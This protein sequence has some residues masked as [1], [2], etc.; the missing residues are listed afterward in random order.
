LEDLRAQVNLWDKFVGWLD[1]IFDKQP[2][3]VT[4]Q[5][6]AVI[7]FTSGTEGKPKAVQLSHANIIANRNQFCERVAFSP[8][9][10]I[11]FNPLPVFHSFGLT[12]GLMVPLLSG[13]RVF[14]YPTPLHYKVIPEL[15]RDTRATILFSIDTFLAQYA[16]QAD[17]D[18]FQ[19]LRAIF[20][21]AEKVKEDTRQTYWQ[22][23]NLRILEGYGVTEASPVVAV[24][25]DTHFKPGTVGRLM[26]GVEHRLEKVPGI[27]DGAKLLIK[28][29]NVMVGYLDH[30]QT[31]DDGWYDTGDIVTVDDEGFVTIAGRVKRFAKIAGEMISL[32]VVEDFAQ[33]CWPESAHAVVTAPDEKRGEMLVLFT[34]E[35]GADTGVLSA[36][37][38]QSGGTELMAPKRIVKLAE[39]PLLGSGK[40]DYVTLRTMV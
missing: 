32:N 10:D 20:A 9:T 2:A 17:R 31:L 27:T 23:F 13:I 6:P 15:V 25:T 14:Q 5:S 39:L 11:I 34:T 19:S 21:G 30:A 12:G 16:R 1:F 28:G 24:N 35:Q 26:P 7:L 36:F 3:H 22:K 40:T 8:E 37:I 29:P 4:P 33:K 18:D 38:K